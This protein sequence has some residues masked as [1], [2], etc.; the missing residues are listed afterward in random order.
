MNYTNPSSGWVGLAVIRVPSL[1]PTTSPSYRG[2][3]IINPGGPGGSG[4]SLVMRSGMDFSRILDG[5]FDIIGLDPRGK[6][7]VH[8]RSLTH[9]RLL[10][11]DWTVNASSQV[12]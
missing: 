10:F 2:P 5:H 6:L 8:L 1:F 3:L 7:H 11:R 9:D 4:V 12:L